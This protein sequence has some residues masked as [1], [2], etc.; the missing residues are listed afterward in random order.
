MSMFSK[1][2]R[3]FPKPLRVRLDSFLRIVLQTALHAVPLRKIPSKS[4]VEWAEPFVKS[5]RE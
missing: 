3:V 4:H 1:T 5:P 2:R